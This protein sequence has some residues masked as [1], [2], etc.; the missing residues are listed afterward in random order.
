LRLPT[1]PQWRAGDRKQSLHGRV[2][3]VKSFRGAAKAANPGIHKYSGRGTW[4]GGGAVR[5]ASRGL[6][7]RTRR[8][9]RQFTAD[10][11]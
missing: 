9:D 1:R 8:S 3:A 7:V 10:W 2:S 4:I 5:G 6:S 11:R